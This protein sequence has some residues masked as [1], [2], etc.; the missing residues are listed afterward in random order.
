MPAGIYIANCYDCDLNVPQKGV[1][2]TGFNAVWKL[3]IVSKQDGTPAAR[4]AKL[5]HN[6]SHAEGAAGLMHA[7][8]RAFGLTMDSDQ[9]EFVS[10]QCL[11]DLSIEI[12]KVGKNEGREQN[13]IQA[14][15]P[16]KG[17]V[18][19]VGANGSSAGDKGEDPW[20]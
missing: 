3:E 4:K 18:A 6:V 16:L 15:L 10:E 1:G 20:T 8:F 14:L 19:A 5:T 9:D 17:A 12:Q 11:V 13:R 2:A 7:A